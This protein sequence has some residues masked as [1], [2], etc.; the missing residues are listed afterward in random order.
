MPRGYGAPVVLSALAL[1]ELAAP[2]AQVSQRV[3]EA[4]GELAAYGSSAAWRGAVDATLAISR[5]PKHLIRPQLVLLG[6]IGGGGTPDD[7]R[8]ER[9]AVGVELLHLFLLVHDDVM[10]NASRR[11]GHPTLHVALRAKDSGIAWPVARDLAIVMGNMLNV[12]AMRHLMPDGLGGSTAACTLIL[13]ACSHAGAGQFQDL[14]GWRRLGD[15]EAT[16]RRAL[17]DKTA[18]QAFAAPL[19]AGLALVRADA[20]V[21]PAL[22]WGC[23]MGLAFQVLD[24]LA[25]LVSPP[26]VTGKDALRDLLEGHPSLP[27]LVLHQRAQGDDL[28]LL[29]SV[30]GRGAVT[31]AERVAIDRLVDQYGVVDACAEYVRRELAGCEQVVGSALTPRA[32]EGMRTVARG[33]AAHLDSVVAHARATR[34]S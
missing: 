4:I 6:G 27:L 13:D 34:R 23:R 15:D 21:Q 24:D 25:D 8:L 30:V 16:L 33:L 29:W 12:L 22:A 20:D 17:I 18:Y 19:A 10:D 26:A 14:L 11:R 1:D 7:P 32:R 3:D 28:E 2:L 5:A 9:F 31:P